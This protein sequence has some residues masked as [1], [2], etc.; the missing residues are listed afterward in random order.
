MT[1]HEQELEKLAEL[2]NELIALIFETGNIELMDKFSE[3]QN[4]RTKCNES[5]LEMIEKRL[6]ND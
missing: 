3:W 1:K 4:Q 2:E 5:L 6:K